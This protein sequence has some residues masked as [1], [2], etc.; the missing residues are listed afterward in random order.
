MAPVK[1][2]FLESW[3]EGAVLV[4]EKV[5]SLVHTDSLRR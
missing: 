3:Q 5:L 1:V 2:K 4:C